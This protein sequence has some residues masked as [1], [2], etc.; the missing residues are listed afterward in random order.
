MSRKINKH[1]LENK[2]WPSLLVLFDLPTLLLLILKMI[3]YQQVSW[4]NN[5]KHLNHKDWN[6]QEASFS[7]IY[8]HAS[9]TTHPDLDQVFTARQENK[10]NIKMIRR[11]NLFVFTLY[12]R[13]FWSLAR[14]IMEW[15][16]SDTV[17][18]CHRHV[19]R[20]PPHSQQPP[21]IMTIPP[22]RPTICVIVAGCQTHGP[23][24]CRAISGSIQIQ[25]HL[26]ELLTFI[27]PLSWQPSP[28]I[29]NTNTSDDV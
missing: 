26:P 7:N 5:S 17:A 23:D 6:L 16:L 19:P 9:E 22:L 12:H 13:L 27:S 20:F 28:V 4:R 2:A 29:D 24:L 1:C 18:G 15:R 14:F 10:A 21:I 11:H 25:T 8:I 3:A